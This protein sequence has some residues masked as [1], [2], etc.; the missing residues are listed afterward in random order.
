MSFGVLGKTG[1]GATEH[2]GVPVRRGKKGRKRKG[3]GHFD[4]L[5]M[6]YMWHES[7]FAVHVW[8]SCLPVVFVCNFYDVFDAFLMPFWCQIAI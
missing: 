6:E 4:W 7:A 8:V 5:I 3:M 1:R 2:A